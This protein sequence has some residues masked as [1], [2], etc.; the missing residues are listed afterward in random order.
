MTVPVPT[1]TPESLRGESGAAVGASVGAVPEATAPADMADAPVRT[2]PLC[3]GHRFAA[4][5]RGGRKTARCV[6]CGARERTRLLGLALPRMAP[7]PSGAPVY[8]FAPEKGIATLLHRLY[9]AAYTPADLLPERYPG[10]PV[11]L[12]QVDLCWPAEYIDG[13]IQGVV[14]SH[15]LDRIPGPIE[16]TIRQLNG[17]IELGGFHVFQVPIHVGWYREDVDPALPP[18]ERGK[19]FGRTDHMRRFGVQDFQERVLDL[20]D[21]FERVPVLDV[22]S[23]QEV[24]GAAVKGSAATSLTGLSV[25]FF[26]KVAETPTPAF[27]GP[28]AHRPALAAVPA[29]AA[30]PASPGAAAP[31]AAP[32]TAAPGA[33]ES[34]TAAPGAAAS[35]TAAPARR[36]RGKRFAPKPPRIAVAEALGF[37]HL[38]APEAVRAYGSMMSEGEKA[39]LHHAARSLWT[40]QGV[41]LD[42]GIFLGA[43]TN[44]FADGLRGNPNLGARL[45]GKP[46]RSYDLGIWFETFARHLSPA[47]LKVLGGEIPAPGADYGHALRRSLAGALDLVD[48]NLGDIVTHPHDGAPVE[49]AFYDC[50]KSDRLDRYAFATFA[51]HYIPGTTIVIYQDFFYPYAPHH[52][53]RQE[54]LARHFD[55]LGQISTSAIF[56]LREA[57]PAEA[58]AFQPADALPL[59]E[60]Q[61]LIRQAAERSHFPH[62]MWSTRLAAIALAIEHGDQAL[63]AAAL[64]EIDD[65]IARA[66]A[67]DEMTE[68]GRRTM[69]QFRRQVAEMAGEPV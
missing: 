41:I 30:A 7:P 18:D 37:D 8:H 48:L 22:M 58:L 44:A 27:G 45:P 15:V 23:V 50:L 64:A 34:P 55:Y 31:T 21:G 40:G 25:F 68:G 60:Q 9:G 43:S 33:A 10:A 14:H 36:V 20:F 13:P 66:G 24:V 49:I 59:A 52:K 29:A 51:P 28:R 12:R 63:A 3:G 4:A 56:R 16:R 38:A 67:A 26:R 65:D 57:L 32:A 47:A 5:P 42:A 2:C 61:A 46:V 39:F 1:P 53:V 54:Y 35:P 17:L 69:R 62:H 11:P 6:G 19:A